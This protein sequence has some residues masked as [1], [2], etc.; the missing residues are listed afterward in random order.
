MINEVIYLCEKV[1]TDLTG[2]PTQIWLRGEGEFSVSLGFLARN[3][4]KVLAGPSP[5]PV[6]E[7]T[8][9]GAESAA[10]ITSITIFRP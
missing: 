8:A 4:S 2:S 6:L 1:L 9:Y 3:L 7:I 5:A 10:S